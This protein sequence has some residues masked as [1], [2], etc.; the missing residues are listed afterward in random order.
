MNDSQA[1]AFVETEIAPRYKTLNDTQVADW[2]RSLRPLDLS[3]AVLVAHEL[4]I[5]PDLPFNIKAFRKL[6]WQR[7]PKIDRQPPDPPG[8]DP[9][10]RCLQ[11]PANHPDWQDQERF[12]S[13]GFR[14]ADCGR[15]Q[16]V[17][18]YA[19]KQ[20]KYAQTIHGGR[21]CAVVRPIEN[22]PYSGPLNQ[23][24]R[25]AAAEKHILNGPDGPG[26]RFLLTRQTKTLQPTLADGTAPA[27]EPGEEG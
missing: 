11:P 27:R 24:D 20:A 7:K 19:E 1:T 17:A 9:Y 12:R 22:T 10:I 21:W 15:K 13:E 16:Y 14:R 25:A 8:F 6:A 3:L 4:A 5:D 26:K 23:T 18:E 2:V